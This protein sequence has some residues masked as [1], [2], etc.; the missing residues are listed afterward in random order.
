[1]AEK[2]DY[3]EV[4]G[5][6]K[7]ASEEEIKKAFRKLA[8]EHHPDL[9]PDNKSAEARFKE[10]NE[11]YEVLSDADKKARYDQFGH[12]GVDP[13]YGGGGGFGGIDIDLGDIFESF[14]GGGGSRRAN[15]NAP[16][17]GENI[18]TI[19]NITFEEAAF[20]CKK[21]IPL[22]RIEAC[23][24]CGGNGCAQGTTPEVCRHCG[25]TG[26][27]RTQQRTPFGVMSSSTSCAECGGTGKI[28]HD[29]C[30]TC[31]GKGNVRRNRTITV[32]I[33]AGIDSGQTISV[34][35]QGNR[36]SN[37][38][39]NGDL[40]VTVQIT[41]HESFER[42]GNSVLY[43]MPISIVQAA[44]GAEVEVPTLD[45]KVKYKIPEGTQTDTVFRLRGKEF[46]PEQRRERRSVCDR[47]G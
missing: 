9:N 29:P 1:M 35:D 45:G 10:I 6:H 13:S 24:E 32:N 26:T 25:G 7:G 15:Q 11:A 47:Y 31:K 41:P 16:R 21:E 22:S 40:L 17:K 34:R 3:Y 33:P 2:R 36:G 28:I 4:L 39:P 19:F 20:G 44:I 43:H 23:A 46:Q 12:A 14:F 38:G 18:R 42:E 5:V 37:G 27:V 30:T 8:K